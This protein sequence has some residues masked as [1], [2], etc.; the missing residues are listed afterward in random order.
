MLRSQRLRKSTLALDT[1]YAEGQRRYV[2]SLSSYARQFLGQVQKPKVE[3]VTGLS[4]AISIEQKDAPARVRARPSAR[5]RKSTTTCGFCT[6]G[7]VKR[8]ARTATSRSARNRPMR[9]SKKILGLPDG[10]KLYIMAPLDR[11]GQEKY[12][13]I[14]DEIRRM[15]YVRMRI[16]G[17]SYNVE[18]PPAIDHRRKHLI[19]IV[20]D[21]NVI[22]PNTR[23][24]YRRSGRA[25]TRSRSRRD[26]PGAR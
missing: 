10:T 14:W 19:E 16:D 1:I 7:S 8:I 12:E 2:E 25:G 9:L 6:P 5:S 13:A 22:R 3:H 11:K 18:E 4:P 20:V 17:K 23:H 15:G 24:P 26:A 21:R